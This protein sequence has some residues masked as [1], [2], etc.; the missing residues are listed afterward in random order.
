[1]SNAQYECERFERGEPIQIHM[2]RR[3]DSRS[4]LHRHIL[5]DPLLCNFKQP[6]Q[7]VTQRSRIV[8]ADIAELDLGHGFLDL[9]DCIIS[10]KRRNEFYGN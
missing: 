7:R 10:P 5:L 2:V 6:A 1:M 4:N 8:Q 3:P 9:D